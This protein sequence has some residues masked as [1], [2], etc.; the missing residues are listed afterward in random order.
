[1]LIDVSFLY[2]LYDTTDQY[3][4]RAVAFARADRSLQIVPDVA[5]SEVTHLLLR[6]LG[7]Y[8]MRTFVGTFANTSIELAPITK[9]DLK[10]A[11]EIMTAYTDVKLDFVD[12]CIMALAERLNITRICTFDRRDFAV[13]KPV[14]CPY[15]ELLP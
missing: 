9:G 1:M 12:C 6:F 11:H 3:H 14:H 8:A 10:R 5:L 15:L 4:K 2:A 13:F 7:H